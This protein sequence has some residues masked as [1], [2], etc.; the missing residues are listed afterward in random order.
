[1]AKHVIYI[2][3]YIHICSTPMAKAIQ[4]VRACDISGSFWP[5]S[6]INCSQFK[7]SICFPNQYLVQQ[8]QIPH[9]K[10]QSY[11]RHQQQKRALR[12]KMRHRHQ[13]QQASS[14][15]REVFNVSIQGLWGISIEGLWSISI[16]GLCSINTTLIRSIG[17]SGG[18]RCSL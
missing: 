13:Q 11:R 4:N 5:I 9:S 17:S 18:V 3:I 16:M 15:S 6:R 2:Y 14:S 8:N 7:I 10:L 12:A 1:M